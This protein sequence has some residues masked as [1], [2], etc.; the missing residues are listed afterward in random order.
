MADIVVGL[1]GIGTLLTADIERR[2][3]A[4]HDALYEAA[5]LGAEVVAGNAP[6]D[7]GILRASVHAKRTA[8]GAEI[9]VD[10]PHAAVVELGARPHWTPIQPLLDYAKR[11][12][13]ESPWAMA[14]SIQERIATEGQRPRMFVR[15]SLPVLREVLAEMIRRRLGG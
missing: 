11:K 12:G 15:R 3:E 6:V 10:A 13:A 8:K 2:S 9:V 5:L 4:L 1:D 7:L 14:R